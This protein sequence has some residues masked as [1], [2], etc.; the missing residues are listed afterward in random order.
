[1]VT[2]LLTLISLYGLAVGVF[3]ILENRRPQATL[4]WLLVFFFAPGI[5]VLIYLFFGRDGKAFSKRRRLLMQ[6]L[7]SNALPLLAPLLSR[8]DAAIARL[9]GESPS[10]RKLMQLVRRNSR[11]ALT[12]HNRVEIQQD[13][14]VFYPSMMADMQ[15]AR[16]SI[17]LQYFIWRADE[18]TEGLKE[19]LR[20]KVEEGVEVRLL[21]DPVGSQAPMHRTYIRAMQA[22]GV[23]MAPTS[24]LYQV[25]TIS[26]R[27]HRKITVI[28]GRI[29]YTGGM[30]IGQEHLDGGKDFDAWRDTQVR[31]VG[32]GAALLQAVFMVDWYNAV[33]E[34]LFAA[35]YFP[36]ETRDTSAVTALAEPTDGDVPVQILTSGPDAQWAAIRQ[37]YSFMIVTAQR[38]VFLQSPYF[39]LDASIAEA[40]T[41]AALSGVDVQVMLSARAS[42]NKLP[43]WAGNTYI[44]DVVQ[45][46]VRVFLYQKGYLHAKT[47]SIDSSICSIGSVNIDIRS[48]SI[49]YELNAVLYSNRLALELEQA[50][51]R[52]LVHCIA[53][54]ATAYKNRNA[55][56]RFRD[57]VARLFSPLL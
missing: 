22:A 56:L 49:N 3:L 31:I 30:N 4:A 43:G 14:A 16:H 32:D 46:G 12:R 24:P 13:A 33:R 37:L 7:E 27:N 34:N 53:F 57:S 42:G 44:A 2:I 29:G 10:H 17:H 11:S 47:I 15:A 51:E 20:A 23:R 55:V 9:E 5:G 19:L 38:H 1:M 18:F 25:H 52:D 41:S 45:A 28:D 50:F 35:A 48:F 54:D 21:Y 36:T 26:Y 39:V 8:Q 6:D 40:L